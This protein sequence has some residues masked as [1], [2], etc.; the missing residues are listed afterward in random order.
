MKHRRHNFL[1][2]YQEDCY[3]ATIIYNE[4]IVSKS[5]HVEIKAAAS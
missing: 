1:L 5:R 2:T 3:A 4:E